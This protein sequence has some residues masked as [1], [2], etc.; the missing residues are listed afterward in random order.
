MENNQNSTLPHDVNP[1][2][3]YQLP[4]EEVVRRLG[5]DLHAGL[6]GDEVRQHH[7]RYGTNEIREGVRRGPLDVLDNSP[8][9]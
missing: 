3:W 1:P 2:I 8:I 7:E 6:T 9:S 5:V 4:T